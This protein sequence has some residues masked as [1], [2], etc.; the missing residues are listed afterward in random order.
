[1]DENSLTAY[2]RTSSVIAATPFPASADSVRSDPDYHRLVPHPAELIA[3]ATTTFLAILLNASGGY[4]VVNYC[5]PVI[6]FAIMAWGNWRLARHNSAAIWTPLF[7]LR[8]STIAFGCIGGILP[9]VIRDQTLDFLLSLY[10]F[11]PADASKV[12]IIWL[13]GTTA[14]LL[15]AT[16]AYHIIPRPKRVDTAD[17]SRNENTFA[18]GVAFVAIGLTNVIVL[19]LG[20]LL[21]FLTIVVPGSVHMLLDALNSVGIFLLSLWAF[22]RGGS[23][24]W[25]VVLIVILNILIGLIALNKTMALFPVLFVGIGA[26]VQRFTLMRAFLVAVALLSGMIVLQPMVANA[27]ILQ[28]IKYGSDE[29]GT[30]PE[31]IAFYT[32]YLHGNRSEQ[33]RT[34]SDEALVRFSYMNVSAYVVSQYDRHMPDNSFQNIGVALVPRFIWKDKPILTQSSDDLYYALTGLVGSAV[35]ASV[36]PDIYWNAGWFGV[37]LIPILFGGVLFCISQFSADI[38]RHRDWIMMPFV[39]M[40]FR[41]GM[42]MDGSFVVSMF[43]PVIVTILSYPALRV[44]RSLVMR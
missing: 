5:A 14:M 25:L 19:D 4:Q 37:A 11:T 42:S 36:Y 22:T 21:G 39:L 12:N 6:M 20:R 27:R 15:G 9:Y 13:L 43:L 24:Y 18:I 7:S 44:F 38:V 8:I 29:T 2:L 3:L 1:M 30:I 31:R 10:P 33:T 34:G 35:S 32:D 16:I 26:L 40:A 28:S 41:I 23:R 17:Y